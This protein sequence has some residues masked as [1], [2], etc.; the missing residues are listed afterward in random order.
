[1]LHKMFKMRE[2]FAVDLG[3][4]DV[5]KPFLEHLEDLRTMIVRIAITLIVA[6]FGT[7]VFYKELIQIIL[8]PLVWAEVSPDRSSAMKLLIST[9][10]TGPFMTAMNVAMIAAIIVAFPVL[11]LFLFQF[12]L[13]GLKENEKKMIFPAIT[14]GAGLFL[15]G[16][17]FSYWLVL[18]KALKFFW[19]FGTDMGVTPM[20]TLNLYI[21][22]ATRFILIF[23]VSFE[24]PILVM[25]LVKLGIL[26]YKIMKG[27]RGHAIV[28]IA[29]FAAVITPTQ[30][31]LTLLLM[32]LPLYFLYEI[33]IWL[34]Y[35]IDKKDRELYPEYYKELEADEATTKVS[36]DW[37]NEDYNPWSTADDDEEETLGKAKTGTTTT[38]ATA[39]SADPGSELPAPT[40]DPAPDPQPEPAALTEPAPAPAPP[41]TEKSLEDFAREDEKQRNQD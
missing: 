14:V 7:F 33:C 5:E 12:I 6:V 3:Q 32:I 22:F 41:E 29:V 40:L 2:K 21:T 26:N 11:L 30:D 4:G 15:T 1:M 35:Y 19:E 36:D 10:P 20:W 18:P 16:I 8:Q 25:V 9:D 27:T 23:G 34:A 37:D 28:G 24:L 13:P 39:A 17:G 31:A 38:T